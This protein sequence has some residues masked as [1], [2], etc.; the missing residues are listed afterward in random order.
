MRLTRPIACTS[1]QAVASTDVLDI[2]EACGLDRPDIS[3]IAEIRDMRQGNLV[4]ETLKKLSNL[5]IEARARTNVVKQEKFSQRLRDAIARYHNR[6]VDALQVIQEMIELAK[7]LQEEG[8]ERLSPEEVAFYD[9]LAANE[10]AVDVLGNDQL[11]V[12]A[13]ELVRTVRAT[14]SVDWWAARCP[15]SSSRP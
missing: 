12:I 9:A 1:L 7:K 3:V 14:W 5:E 13:S 4:V 11:V 15:P 2:L 10:S 8:D 6:S